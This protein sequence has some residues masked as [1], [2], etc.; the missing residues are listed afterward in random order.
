MRDINRLSPKVP[1][2][3]LAAT[4]TIDVVSI[5]MGF[6]L[7]PHLRLVVESSRPA[8]QQFNHFAAAEKEA[9]KLAGGRTGAK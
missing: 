6:Y 5:K 8:P 1:D 3:A 2:R 7:R 4:M 9:E